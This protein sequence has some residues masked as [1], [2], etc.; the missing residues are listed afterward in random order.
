M[1]CIGVAAVWVCAWEP[2][3]FRGSLAPTPPPPPHVHNP[4]IPSRVRLPATPSTPRY[5]AL[6]AASLAHP[7][8]RKDDASDVGGAGAGAGAGA[9]GGAGKGGAGRMLKVDWSVNIGEHVFAITAGR[10]SKGLRP[11]QVDIVV[12]GTC[13]SW[14]CRGHCVCACAGWRP[15]TRRHMPSAGTQSGRGCGCVHTGL[16]L[17]SP[18]V[19]VPGASSGE[20]TLFCLK[21]SGSSAFRLQKRLDYHPSAVA[22]YNRPGPTDGM[23][24]VPPLEVHY[25]CGLT[26]E[27]ACMFF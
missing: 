10:C 26:I 13:W 8:E 11:S 1:T 25:C 23:E 2:C 19:A 20:H 27:F 9:G 12:I 15:H 17:V 7:S 16:H 4:T 22:L 3:I 6:A 18:T 24:A 21:E 14:Q 5:Q